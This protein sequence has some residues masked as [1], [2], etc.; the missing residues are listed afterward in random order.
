VEEYNLKTGKEE[1]YK[2]KK[3]MKDLKILTNS[4]INTVLA[5]MTFM[6]DRI[7]DKKALLSCYQKLKIG[8]TITAT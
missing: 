3:W 6:K 2:Y 4:I 5:T 1:I 7:T 8:T